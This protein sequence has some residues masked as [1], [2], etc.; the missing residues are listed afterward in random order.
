VGDRREFYDNLIRLVVAGF[1]HLR[2]EAAQWHALSYF[3]QVAAL[4]QV[5]DCW[6][7]LGVLKGALQ[8]GKLDPGA[9]GQVEELL[10]A[11][12]KIE[13]LVRA[14]EHRLKPTPSRE[15]YLKELAKGRF[16]KE[17]E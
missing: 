17:V 2:A 5:D 10:K 16:V 6:R 4:E 14:L 15:E 9:A 13:P 3:D 1:A 8:E 7:D 11:A 12:E